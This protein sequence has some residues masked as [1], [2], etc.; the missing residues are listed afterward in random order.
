MKYKQIQND[1][2]EMIKNITDYAQVETDNLFAEWVDNKMNNDTFNKVF[3]EGNTI[4]EMPL[5]DLSTPEFNTKTIMIDALTKELGDLEDVGINPEE[6]I[7]LIKYLTANIED[8]YNGNKLL[9]DYYI[10]QGSNIKINKG[11]KVTKG[12]KKIVNKEESVSDIQVKLS[13]LI[14]Q[15]SIDG[16]LCVSRDPR[17]YI[18]LSDNNCDWSSCHNMIN[19]DYKAGNINYMTDKVTLVVYICS[20]SKVKIHGVEWN[21]KKYRRL[22]HINKN[23]DTIVFN[24]SYPF[25]FRDEK[26]KI[27]ENRITKL[28]SGEYLT[29]TKDYNNGILFFENKAYSCFNILAS[30]T[31]FLGYNDFSQ[32]NLKYIEVYC[33]N[34]YSIRN[35]PIVLNGETF[36]LICGNGPINYCDNLT[37]D[38]HFLD[39][40]MGQ[41][42]DYCCNCDS[43]LD[44]EDYDHIFEDS[45]GNYWCEDCFKEYFRFCELECEYILKDECSFKCDECPE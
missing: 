39:Y 27:I 34:E 13:R 31:N 42:L 20:K 3:G 23:A 24:K 17:D 2:D 16:I 41:C 37:C 21:N 32:S 5:E 29:L 6:K 10:D 28:F 45:K 8:L 7:N 1:F 4:I 40:G 25:N 30:G 43:A 22:I 14:Q 35:L 33:K 11:T 9:K 26:N 44:T 12:I 19:G 38:E 15:D 36:C 18:T